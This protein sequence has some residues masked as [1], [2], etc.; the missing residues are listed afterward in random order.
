[1][2]FITILQKNGVFMQS[3]LY[4]RGE[5]VYAK[6]GSGFIRLRNNGETSVN[7]VRWLDIE[8]VTMEYDTLG[9]MIIE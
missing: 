3:D 9:R 5:G 4:R 8:G 1:M 6:Q 7:N 2:N